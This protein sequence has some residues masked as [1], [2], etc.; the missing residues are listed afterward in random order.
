MKKQPFPLGMISGAIGQQIVIKQY[1]NGTV[2]SRYPKK[3]GVV[4]SKS[5]RECRNL[6]KSGGGICKGKGIS[7][8]N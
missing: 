3:S 7:G 8:K 6:F 2:I 5:Q 1:R 4:A